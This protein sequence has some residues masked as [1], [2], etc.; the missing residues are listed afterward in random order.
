MYIYIIYFLY[1]SVKN[2]KPTIAKETCDYDE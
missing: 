1:L 2:D